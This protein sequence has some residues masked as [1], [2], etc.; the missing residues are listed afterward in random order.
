MQVAMVTFRKRYLLN[1]DEIREER[2]QYCPYCSAYYPATEGLYAWG[3]ASQ[4]LGFRW[5]NVRARWQR[6][7]PLTLDPIDK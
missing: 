1:K 5:I 2:S 3:S 4:L 7:H 6:R